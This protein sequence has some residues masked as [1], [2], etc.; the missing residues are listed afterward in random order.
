MEILI[1]AVLIIG[2]FIIKS[3]TT[4]K[5]EEKESEVLSDEQPDE[6]KVFCC[7]GQ[8]VQPTE[9]RETPEDSITFE[10]KGYA[11]GKEVRLNPTKITW[12]CSCSCVH[13]SSE[14]G[15]TN[16]ISCQNKGEWQRGIYV[17][18]DKLAFYWKLKFIK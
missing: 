18:Y 9:T 12:K 4:K 13:F 8:E 17:K 7:G 1:I 6:L 16:T 10:V 2:I 14:T 3:T 15:E 5:K 11:K